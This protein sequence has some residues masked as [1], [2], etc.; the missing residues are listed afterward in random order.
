[1]G[2]KPWSDTSDSAANEF[3][4]AAAQWKPTWTSPFMI[5]SVNIWQVPGV[6]DFTFRP[7]L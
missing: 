2:G 1:M 7:M 6:G 5:D 4:A 3:W